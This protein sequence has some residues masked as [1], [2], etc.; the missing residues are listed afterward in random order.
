[1]REETL[2]KSKNGRFELNFI[3]Y[4]LVF[5]ITYD[6]PD[7]ELYVLLGIVYLKISF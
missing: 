4:T 5:G 2:Y 1:M 6:K 3:Q 7:K